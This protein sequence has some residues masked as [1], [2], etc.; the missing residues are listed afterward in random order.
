MA[1]EYICNFMEVYQMIDETEM[2]GRLDYD[3][4]LDCYEGR[5]NWLGKECWITID[6]EEDNAEESLSV[7]EEICRKCDEWDK[8]FKDSIVKH[9]FRKANDFWL[10]TKISEEEFVSRLS[11]FSISVSD[12]EG[13]T[14]HA[15]YSSDGIFTDHGIVVSGNLVNGVKYVNLE[16]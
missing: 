11:L 4:I 16:G 3:T 14:F 12:F 13:G 9:L 5:F 8:I 2:F 6:N 15:D 1:N 7:A 10:D